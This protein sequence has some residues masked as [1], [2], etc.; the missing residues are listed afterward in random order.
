MNKELIEKITLEDN[1]LFKKIKKLELF[2]ITKNYNILPI[3]Q[4]DLLS[5]Q[6]DVMKAYHQVLVARVKNLRG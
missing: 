2:I 4:Q 6:L 3:I 1:E 5:L